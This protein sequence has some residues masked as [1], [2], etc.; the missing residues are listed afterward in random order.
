VGWGWWRVGGGGVVNNFL[1]IEESYACR[2][3]SGE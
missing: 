3:L 2:N 1:V